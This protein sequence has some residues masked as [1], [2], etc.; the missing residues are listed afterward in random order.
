MVKYRTKREPWGKFW[1]LYLA[2]TCLEQSSL[3]AKNIPKCELNTGTHVIYI[4]N[5][6]VKSLHYS[7]F[8][9]PSVTYFLPMLA[10]L[11][12]HVHNSI[13]C[14]WYSVGMFAMHCL[15]S[16]Y[17]HVQDTQ[18]PCSQYSVIF[19]MHCPCSWCTAIKTAQGHC[20]SYA[21]FYTLS[22]FLIRSRYST[23]FLNP[24][25]LLTFGSL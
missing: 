19:T 23:M 7:C 16:Q 10:I 24:N 17:S 2:Q 20:S 5:L 21:L 9:R 15:C 14:L 25:V 4:P 3:L 22:I 12:H 18:P 1:D 13:P 11:T 6:H 8:P